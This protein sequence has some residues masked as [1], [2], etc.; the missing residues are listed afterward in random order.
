M[1]LPVKKFKVFL[2]FRSRFFQR[3]PVLSAPHSKYEIQL[4]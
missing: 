4:L 2:N 1:F 3:H